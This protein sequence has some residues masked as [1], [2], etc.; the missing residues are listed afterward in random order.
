MATNTFG[1]SHE[2]AYLNVIPVSESTITMYNSSEEVTSLQ[3]AKSD[4]KQIGAIVVSVVLFFVIVSF[5]ALKMFCQL[6]KRC[7]QRNLHRVHH[8]MISNGHYS[9][10]PS[11]NLITSMHRY[12]SSSWTT[13]D[14]EFEFPR[15]R[16]I[17]SGSILGEGAFGQ[18]VLGVASGLNSSNSCEASG[19]NT[20]CEQHTVA[21]KMLKVNST[22]HER[23]A[24]LSEISMMKNIGKHENI[25]N[26]LGCCTQD[27]PLFVLVEYAQNGNLREFLRSRR[28]PDTSQQVALLADF[29]NLTNR[30]IITMAYQ[31]AKGMEFLCSKKCIHR[32][33]AARNVLVTE[34]LVMKIADF[35]LARDIHYA[36]YYKK[37]T[38]APL[39]VK[40]MAP[41]ALFDRFFTTKSDVWSYGVLL[42]EIMTLGGTPYPSVPVESI[43]EH[44]KKGKRMEKPHHCLLEVY[45]IMKETW[46]TNPAS[47]PNFTKLMES[48]TQIT[49]MPKNQDYLDMNALGD[50][51]LTTFHDRKVFYNQLRT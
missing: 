34:D 28:P 10:D 50:H 48:F 38:N 44:L 23:N 25:I 5:I 12:L 40:W 49:E 42:W 11:S 46:Q 6:T 19:R 51:P 31:V 47:R 14:S 2:H 1:V 33:L 4:T 8:N 43:F 32:D 27:G 17:L 30:D 15:E 20:S 24:L 37:A 9:S 21:V 29:P 36:D 35:G 26:M 13:T 45:E 39:P 7:Y 3:K 22:D 16:L 41:E 18:V